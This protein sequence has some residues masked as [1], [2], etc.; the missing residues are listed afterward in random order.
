MLRKMLWILAMLALVG[1]TYWIISGLDSELQCYEE[2]AEE[3]LQP[4]G[5]VTGGKDEGE[6]EFDRNGSFFLEYR[7]QRDRTRAREIEMLE[8]LINQSQAGPEAKERAGTML[9]ELIHRVEQE[10]LVEN[11]LRAQGYDDAIFFFRNRS[12]TVMI[13]KNELSER[14][15][16]QI[17]DAVATIVGIEREEVAVITRP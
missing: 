13:K 2:I 15:F 6:Q 17:T 14:E 12:A 9:L 7:L 16:V 1:G 11:M 3:G 5:P 10:L 8:E 4:A